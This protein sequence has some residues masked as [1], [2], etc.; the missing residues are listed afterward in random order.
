MLL[1]I[2]VFSNAMLGE[3]GR[4]AT[5]AWIRVN[6][7]RFAFHPMLS[8]IT[9]VKKAE[10]FAMGTKHA[11]G[12]K[13]EYELV[14]AGFYDVFALSPRRLPVFLAKVAEASTQRP[15]ESYRLPI[16]KVAVIR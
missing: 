1:T 15:L 16:E 4:V 5:R 6:L 8:P 10:E 2:P 3:A 11:G 12:Q 14:K 9:I 13:S 7:R